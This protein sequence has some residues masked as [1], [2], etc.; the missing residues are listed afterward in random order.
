MPS[1]T[2]EDLLAAETLSDGP[3][4]EMARRVANDAKTP[5]DIIAIRIGDLLEYLGRVKLANDRQE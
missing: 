3:E 4:A 5:T 1:L 2:I